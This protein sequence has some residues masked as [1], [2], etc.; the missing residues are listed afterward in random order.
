[1]G[2]S[3]DTSVRVRLLSCPP[4]AAP[5]LPVLVAWPAPRAAGFAG[6]DCAAGVPVPPLTPPS[7]AHGARGPPSVRAD[8]SVPVPLFTPSPRP[9][10]ARPRPVARSSSWVCRQRCIPPYRPAPR[11]GTSATG[12]SLQALLPASAVHRHW[13]H[14][15]IAVAWR[16]RARRCT[17]AEVTCTAAASP[18]QAPCIATGP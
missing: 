6:P 14:G 7:P 15:G 12:D 2:L 3:Y 17:T 8:A 18:Q 5:P 1:V 9:P 11:S 16:H 10:S 13:W 4:G